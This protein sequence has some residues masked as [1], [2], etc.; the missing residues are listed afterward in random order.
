V[1]ELARTFGLA[2]AD[3]EDSQDICFVPT[4]RYS[5]IIERLRPDAAAPGDIVDLSGRVL[6]R[7]EGIIHFTVGQRKG[8]KIAAGE[9]LY[10][11]RLEADT[12]RVVVGP[13]AALATRTIHLHDVNWIGDGVLESA[14]QVFVKVRSTRPPRA[15]WLSVGRNGVEVELADSEEG[16]APGQACV[17]YDSAE[18]GARMLGGGFIKETVAAGVPQREAA[19]A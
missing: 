11:V 5:D 8:L 10:V 18:G 19:H 3:K 17:L 7:H 1:R 2:I 15:A 9:P 14:Q 4:G 6:G 13:R 16:V 12:A